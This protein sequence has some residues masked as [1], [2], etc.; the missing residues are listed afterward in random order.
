MWQV[1]RFA[2]WT[3]AIILACDFVYSAFHQGRHLNHAFK[4]RPRKRS[5]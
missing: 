5:R 1:L 3:I 4:W 2:V